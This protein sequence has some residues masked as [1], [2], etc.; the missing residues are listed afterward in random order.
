MELTVTPQKAT[1]KQ[2]VNNTTSMQCIRNNS[3]LEW[4]KNDNNAMGTMTVS[5]SSSIES[6]STTT[7]Y[8]AGIFPL[9][10]A[11]TFTKNVR[12]GRNKSGSRHSATARFIKGDRK[13]NTRMLL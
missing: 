5:L 13:V 1:G 9:F 3:G 4:Q 6:P 12:G 7:A 2:K 8:K 11:E 10:D